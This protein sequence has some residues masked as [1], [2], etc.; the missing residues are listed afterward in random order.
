[1]A[2]VAVIGAGPAG[3]MAAEVLAM[4]G[5]QVTIYEQMPSPARKFLMAGLGGLNI[6]HSGS[7]EALKEMYFHAS[8][9]LCGAIDAF[10]PEAVLDW[11]ASLGEPGFTGSSGK[12]FPQSFKT[13]PLLRAWLRRLEY[14]KAQLLT[15]HSWEGFDDSG[16]LL[17]KDGKGERVVVHSAATVFAMGGA[18]WPR[19]G[20]DGVWVE[21]L[22]SITKIE[23][24]Q[25]SNMG[26]NISWGDFLISGFAGTPLKA[27]QL[28][29][30][31]TNVAGEA[32]IT[33]YGLEGTAVYALS[34]AV[35]QALEHG[36][37][38]MHMDLRPS[39]SEEA[40][41]DRLS[42]VPTKQ[43]VA[44]RLR[45]ALKFSPVERALL[46]EAG[47]PPKS[48]R[49]LAVLIK[50]IPLKI[51]GIQ[52]LERA[53]SCAGGIIENELTDEFMFIGRPGLFAAGEMLNFDA[54][55]GGYLLQAALAS[56]RMAGRGALEFLAQADA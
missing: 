22:Q 48:P 27:I 53:I 55:T 34:A 17:M 24:M 45:R 33:N 10:P 20:S 6:T 38:F 39:L 36:P 49:D 5:H 14:H 40:I 52:G 25:P 32:L 41:I 4:A 31:T 29:L 21:H 43:S 11:M 51:E 56:G 18:S 16:A 23:E 12:I 3:L 47:P 8:P 46:H 35:R 2:E 7:V 42:R 1:M 28:R 50:N 19:L 9:A 30:N 44:N 26:V 54:P 37:A 13:S 15:R